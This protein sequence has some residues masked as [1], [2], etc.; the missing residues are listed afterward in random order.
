[1]ATSAFTAGV[2][3]YVLSRYGFI[4]LPAGLAT[5]IP[6]HQHDRFMSAW[7]AHGA[8]YVVGLV[9]GALLCFRIWK[10]RGRPSVISFFPRTPASTIRAVL[11][12]AA[13]AYILW[14]RFGAH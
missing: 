8:S 5:A 11:L 1:M 12:A 13:V 4:S 2:F 3:G 10:A 7:F 14:I 6:L 9:G